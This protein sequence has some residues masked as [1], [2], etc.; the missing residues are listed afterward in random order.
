M[1]GEMSVKRIEIEDKW[2]DHYM[3]LIRDK[4]VPYMWLALNDEI[5]GAEPSFCIRN[6]RMAANKLSG[7]EAEYPFEGFVFQD[8]DLYKW[9]E[10]VAYLLADEWDDDLFNQAESVIDLIASAQ[11]E[12]GYINTY[13]TLE[14]PDKRWKNLADCHE[15]YCAGH[16]IEAAVAYTE[17][18][19]TDKFLQVAMKFADL[20]VEVS[21]DKPGQIKGYPGHEEIELALIRLWEITDKDEYFELAKFFVFERGKEPNYF[22]EERNSSEFF[23]FYPGSKKQKVI[24]EYH[25]AHA[26]VLEQDVASGHAVR[27]VYLYQAMADI[28]YHTQDERLYEQCEKLWNDI[29]DKQ[30]YVTGGIGQSAL[31]ER[32]TVDYDLPNQHNYSETC[33]SI[34]LANFSR[35]MGSYSH[36]TKYDDLIE[37][38]L[39]NGIASGVS[40]DGESFFYA[41]PMDSWPETSISHTSK[42]HIKAE[43][44]PWFACACCPPNIARTYANLSSYLISVAENVVYLRQY[45]GSKVDLGNRGKIEIDSDYARSGKVRIKINALQAYELV[46]RKPYWSETSKLE[47]SSPLEYT[48]EETIYNL[49]IPKGDYEISIDFSPQVEVII[50]NPE[51]RDNRGLGSVCRG[52]LVYCVEEIDNEIQLSSIIL[53]A[54]GKS[55]YL[56]EK[57]PYIFIEGKEEEFLNWDSDK[58]YQKAKKVTKNTNNIQIKLVPYALWG[59]RINPATQGPGEMKV[60]IRLEESEQN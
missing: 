53:N 16:L 60:W 40:L 47:S 33:A 21:G 42:E 27:A 32:F 8:S 4:V 13:F 25:Q 49:N 15:L 35:R 29:T 2:F 17:A 45:I 26:P 23:E 48:E 19:S 43:R 12:D 37:L 30:L 41:N 55:T 54:D 5:D 34:G 59:N 14:N 18:T 28:A 56:N 10:T 36:K 1:Y 51:V 7:L 52:P 38:E 11:T 31:Y 24:P 44:Q 57:I 6:F 58:L 20:L 39:Y 9:L 50:T 3:D 22:I 46:L